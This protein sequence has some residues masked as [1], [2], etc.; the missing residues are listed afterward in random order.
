MSIPELASVIFGFIGLC[1]VILGVIGYIMA[2]FSVSNEYI[3]GGNSSRFN[4]LSYP[5]YLKR[6]NYRE[7]RAW[8]YYSVRYSF[9]ISVLFLVLATM[10]YKI[11]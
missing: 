7:N 3:K 8:V 6:S 1:A 5:E 4:I 11:S 9:S 2:P 10:I